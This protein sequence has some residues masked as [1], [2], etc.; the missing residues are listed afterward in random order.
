[1]AIELV[2]RGSKM[3]V[4][5]VNG[6]TGD[7]VL[8]AE[9]IGALPIDTEIPKEDWLAVKEYN[10]GNTVY[11]AE[12]KLTT[13]IWNKLQ[14]GLI[15]EILYDVFI[16]GEVFTCEARVNGTD[17][18]II[19][20]NLDFTF[21][22]LPFCIIWAGGNAISGMFFKN[23]SISYPITLKVTDHA[24]V[25]YNKMPVE[26]LPDEAAL[27]SDLPSLSGYATEE[28]VNEAINNIDIPTGGG[29]QP[30]FEQ[31]DSTA[32]DY[33]K[34]KPFYEEI[35]KIDIVEEQTAVCEYSENYECN[36]IPMN[37]VKDPS[38]DLGLVDDPGTMTVF[39]E[40][41]GETYERELRYYYAPK[42]ITVGDYTISFNSEHIL[43]PS[44]VNVGESFTF[45][46]YAIGSTIKTLDTKYLPKLDYVPYNEYAS[47]DEEQQERAR[48][49]IG[50]LNIDE[51]TVFLEDA[52]IFKA[53]DGDGYCSINIDL[54]MP[55][56]DY[57]FDY[58]ELYID[59][60]GQEQCGA[61]IIVPLPLRYGYSLNNMIV[62]SDRIRDI[63]LYTEDS[64]STIL[65]IKLRVYN[66]EA[67]C[68]GMSIRDLKGIKTGYK[69]NYMDVEVV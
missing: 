36:I 6:K 28:F 22:D 53:I 37:G 61:L 32:A 33:I 56:C 16:N 45:R 65:T 48:T 35:G 19:G 25:T 11:I 59:F 30:D 54:Q 66:N 57:E 8:T 55:L 38:W 7:V 51:V 34:N 49:N 18:I 67:L 68:N 5:S 27:K 12:Q 60:S 9:D 10:G 44:T 52:S 29:I 1:M 3:P 62:H 41:N 4:K 69:T 24:E 2:Y 23:G 50:I 31:N 42:D 40:L 14:T 64:D 58:L 20:N 17:G 46:V 43:P 26:Y 39:V 47:L 63:I 21:N 15:T 13:G